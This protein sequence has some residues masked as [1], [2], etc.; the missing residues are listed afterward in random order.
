[1]ND[2]WPPLTQ[3]PVHH[4]DGTPNKY[5][6]IRILKAYRENCNAKWATD[7]CGGCDN[8]LFDLMNTHNDKR[9]AILDRAIAILTK[10]MEDE[11]G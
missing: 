8:P 9:A 11:N 6:P 2:K 7:T 4:V 10:N 5:Y 1:M 3:E